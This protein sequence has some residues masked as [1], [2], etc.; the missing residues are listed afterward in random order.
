MRGGL[1]MVVVGG[2]GRR[3]ATFQGCCCWMVTRLT[4]PEISPLSTG[5][6]FSPRDAAAL[7]RSALR[8]GG[9][10]FLHHLS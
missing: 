2:S 1:V 6:I 7:G 10:N 8:G 3:E 9:G 5:K 4:L